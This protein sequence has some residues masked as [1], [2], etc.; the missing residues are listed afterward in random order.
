MVC[1]LALLDSSHRKDRRRAFVAPHRGMSKSNTK[2]NTVLTSFTCHH[3]CS[4]QKRNSGWEA[5]Y[6]NNSGFYE[7]GEGDGAFPTEGRARRR[8]RGRRGR[9]VLSQSNTCADHSTYHIN[10]QWGAEQR[11]VRDAVFSALHLCDTLTQLQFTHTNTRAHTGVGVLD[12]LKTW[13]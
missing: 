2:C 1:I 8:G 3:C 5:D 9:C 6:S 13:A 12:P 10:K 4:H 7:E 11:H